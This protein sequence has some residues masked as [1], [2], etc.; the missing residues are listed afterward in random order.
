MPWGWGGL[1]GWRP[2]W[3]GQP[4]RID[5]AGPLPL[6][7]STRPPPQ[8]IIHGRTFRLRQGERPRPGM[9]SRLRRTCSPIGVGDDGGE[10]RHETCPYGDGTP[11]RSYFDGASASADLRQHERNGPPLIPIIVRCSPPQRAFSSAHPL[12]LGRTFSP[13]GGPLSAG[14]RLGGSCHRGMFRPR[15]RG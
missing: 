7:P 15:Q 5:S 3:A 4:R 11:F 12:R 1:R 10:G 14:F 2:R 9:D 13:A 6:D 8:R